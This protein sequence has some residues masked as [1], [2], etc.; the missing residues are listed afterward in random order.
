MNFQERCYEVISKVPP[1]KV[2]TYRDVAIALDSKAWRAV[3]TAMAK[4]QRLIEIPCH[5]VVKSDG[6]IGEYAL[7]ADKKIAL[8]RKEGVAIKDGRVVNLSDVRFT[9]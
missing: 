8:L 6:A 1:G 9:L 2:T 4:N 5:R 7:G 3:G